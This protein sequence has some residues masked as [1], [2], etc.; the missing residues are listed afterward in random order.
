MLTSTYDDY[1]LV[2]MGAKPTAETSAVLRFSTDG[3]TWITT[4]TYYNT[5]IYIS[6]LSPTLI[7]GGYSAV[8]LVNLP[9]NCGITYGNYVR[10]RFNRAIAGVVTWDAVQLAYGATA[11]IAGTNTGVL[12]VANPVVGVQFLMNSQQVAS[13]VFSLYG[14][15]K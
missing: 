11:I 14:I 1:E 12:A 9:G 5:Y 7:G 8:S 3:S 6:S 15:V 2:V 4:T 10:L 13:G